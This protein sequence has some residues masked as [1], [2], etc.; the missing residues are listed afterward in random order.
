MN[1][2]VERKV[3]ILHENHDSGFQSTTGRLMTLFS[4]DLAAPPGT[5]PR[6]GRLP[7]TSFAKTPR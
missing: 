5:A 7:V 2:K 3:E 4:R 1:C 6:R